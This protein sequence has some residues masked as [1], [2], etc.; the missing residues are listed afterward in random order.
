MGYLFQVG[1]IFKSNNMGNHRNVAPGIGKR[2]SGSSPCS[3]FLQPPR[4]L[5]S[6][7]TSPPA[8]SD[9]LHVHQL[10]HTVSCHFATFTPGVPS[11]LHRLAHRWSRDA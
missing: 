8:V 6:V 11:T 7:G 10:M 9:V 4:L 1:G 3:T 2:Q 5:D